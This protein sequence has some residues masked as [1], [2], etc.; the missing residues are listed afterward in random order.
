V[1]EGE[2]KPSSGF[3]ALDKLMVGVAGSQIV[4]NPAAVLEPHGAD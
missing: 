2:K 4:I 1:I 3:V